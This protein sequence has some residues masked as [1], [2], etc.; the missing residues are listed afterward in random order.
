MESG[1]SRLG[2]KQLR[3]VGRKLIGRPE[4][5]QSK[6]NYPEPSQSK[7]DCPGSSQ[8]ELGGPEH[9]QSKPGISDNFL[10]RSLDT[11][12]IDVE[13]MGHW[14]HKCDTE[15]GNT[16]R[17]QLGSVVS[18]L[19]RPQL[20][21]DVRKKCLAL[22]ESSHVYACLSY[23]WGGAPTLKTNN[24]NLNSLMRENSL[25]FQ[26]DGIPR[27]IRDTICLVDQLG[28]P[29]L[30]VDSLC[31]VQ[32]DNESKHDQIQ[33]MAGIYA[34]SYVTIIAGNGWD[35]NHGLRGI[36][37]V[38]EPR[39][40]SSFLKTDFEENLQPYSGIW[41]SRGWTLQ[42][43]IFSPRK[44]MFQYQ[45][46]IWECNSNAWHESS[47]TETA[48]LA[49]GLFDPSINP[50]N[51][52][53][54]FSPW[55]DVEQYVS[56]VSDFANRKLTYPEDGL[57]AVSSLLTVMNSSFLG[58][59]ISGLP[60]MFLDEALLWQ[61]AEP[62]QRRGSNSLPSWSWAGWEGQ[63][64]RREWMDH[65]A[66]LKGLRSPSSRMPLRPVISAVTWFFGDT[67]EERT[68]ANIS[69]HTYM[70]HIFDTPSPLPPNVCTWPS[71]HSFV[72][73]FSGSGPFFAMRTFIIFGFLF[74]YALTM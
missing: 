49:S 31:I 16:C 19:G 9:A 6:L 1:K 20:L 36:Q 62:M 33:A 15:H 52:R 66:H 45:L 46:A 65:W 32:D 12:W 25:E 64:I 34:N 56:I 4:P 8:S 69:G 27:T 63:I 7:P 18:A 39:H 57:N 43:M 3:R 54:K 47:L 68:P 30:W 26:R 21:I 70:Y 61:P 13:M 29:Y 51:S 14:M 37:G 53:V 42:E 44:I 10:T 71:F 41:Y 74:Q 11:S 17:G 50:W 58:G 67:L 40:L 72:I 73:E 2:A 59:F 48:T 28:I 22:A 38:T 5:S 55:P 23:V 60:E 35:A 24:G